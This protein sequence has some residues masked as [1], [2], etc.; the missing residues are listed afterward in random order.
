VSLCP[1]ILSH[2]TLRVSGAKILALAFS[3]I[4][5]RSYQSLVIPALA[6][7]TSILVL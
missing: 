3:G 2:D 6:A 4:A 1:F 5:A 7:I